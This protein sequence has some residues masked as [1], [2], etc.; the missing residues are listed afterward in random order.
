MTKDRC[1]FALPCDGSF[2]CSEGD[3]DVN[4][5]DPHR[6]RA[7]VRRQLAGRTSGAEFLKA[8]STAPIRHHPS[9]RIVR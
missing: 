9:A 2:A 3:T 1:A 4:S 8:F 7:L 5:Q 6:E